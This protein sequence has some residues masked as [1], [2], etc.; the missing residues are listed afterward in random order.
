MKTQVLPC[1]REQTNGVHFTRNAH[2]HD[3]DDVD[4][5]GCTPCQGRHCTAR[6]NCTWH[7]AEGELTCGRCIT[8]VRRDLRW[9]SELSALMIT[10]AITDGLDSE[11][12]NLA[13][14]ATDAEAWSWRK[15]TARQGRAWHAS[16]VED[17]DEFHPERVLTVWE[18]MIREDYTH[19]RAEIGCTTVAPERRDWE[20]RVGTDRAHQ[21]CIANHGARCWDVRERSNSIGAAVDYLGRTLHRIANDD[22]QDFP[23][24]RAELK[25]CRQHLEAVLHND[26]KPERG[27]PC[28]ECRKIGHFVRLK[29]EYAHWCTDE[30]CERMHFDADGS[31]VWR[32]PKDAKHWWTQQGYADMLDERRG[33]RIGA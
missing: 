9:I 15:V 8:S 7:I 30:E 19:T 6:R 10:A 14:P 5:R 18:R 20:A 32:C 28:T 11:A 26:T 25:K 13:G 21:S 24:L 22:E 17:D 1:Y 12:A 3:C 33:G 23:L 29:R 16:L 31:D 27:A 4:C 2:R